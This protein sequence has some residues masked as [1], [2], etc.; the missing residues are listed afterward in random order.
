MADIT[1][2]CLLQ[3]RQLLMCRRADLGASMEVKLSQG[4]NVSCLENKALLI[5]GLSKTL[6]NFNPDATLNCLTNDEI[7]NIIQYMYILLPE[8]C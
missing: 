6:C 4:G 3:H 8:D 7:C 1:S 2:A 5:D